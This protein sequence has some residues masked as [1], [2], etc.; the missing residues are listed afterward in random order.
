MKRRVHSQQL[1][2]NSL[3]VHLMAKFFVGGMHLEAENDAH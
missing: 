3:L 2:F 1:T